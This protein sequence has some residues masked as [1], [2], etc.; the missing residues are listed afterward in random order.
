[1][2]LLV[3]ILCEDG[4]VVGAA[5]SPSSPAGPLDAAREPPA[6][7]FVIQGD[8]ILAG[9][10]LPRGRVDGVADEKLSGLVSSH[11]S[12]GNRARLPQRRRFLTLLQSVSLEQRQLVVLARRWG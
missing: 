2:N 12:C 5:D 7:T 10:G 11:L 8:M 1:M 6:N 9:T 3:G 4:V